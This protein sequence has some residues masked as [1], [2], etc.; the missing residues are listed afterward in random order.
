MLNKR[1]I[2]IG[3]IIS[4]F[5]LLTSCDN[6]KNIV[7]SKAGNITK[8]EFNNKL[9]EEVG[10]SVL[11]QIMV[12]KILFNKYKISDAEVKKVEELK[13]QMG[14][15]FNYHFLTGFENENV[16][17]SKIK[18]RIAFEEA[19][20]ASVTEEEIKNYY[21]PKLKTSHILVSYERVATEIKRQLNN[22][23]DF[24]VLA[25]HYSE[26]YSS[27]EN[28]GNLP[29]FG[30]GQMDPEFEKAA[31][32]LEIGQISDPIKVPYG[33]EIIKLTEKKELRP[34]AEEK[35]NIRKK[36]EEERLQN[37]QWQQQFLKELLKR[38]D[39]KIKDKDLRDIL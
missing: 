36:L 28:G 26:D 29:E 23:A 16:P 34:F 30:P 1:W 32:K 14:N 35:E 33:Y 6:S 37:P 11:Q 38:A 12:D 4:S 2:F 27:Q 24:A 17:E 39:T 7:T 25:K 8:N 31:Y 9:K 15:N 18:T 10:K 5:L 19:V 21:K 3:I 22:G 20:K 13:K